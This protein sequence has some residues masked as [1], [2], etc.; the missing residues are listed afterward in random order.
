MGKN[1]KRIIKKKE[2]RL[3]EKRE[4][5]KKEKLEEK[6]KN[7][8]KQEIANIDDFER[9]SKKVLKLEPVIEEVRVERGFV[10]EQVRGVRVPEEKEKKNYFES[11][12]GTKF[13]GY[14][15]PASDSYD[16]GGRLAEAV[17]EKL[18]GSVGEGVITE[19]KKREINEKLGEIV[20]MENV[21]KYGAAVVDAFK[22]KRFMIKYE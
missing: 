8:E 4:L 20:G 9:E 19:E 2:K 13:T 6:V 15:L 17:A 10:V 18:K 11:G 14:D 21:T 22:K 3:K 5:E 12:Y 1:K 16:V 7:E